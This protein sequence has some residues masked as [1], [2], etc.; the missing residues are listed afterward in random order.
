LDGHFRNDIVLCDGL[1]LYKMSAQEMVGE[2]VQGE[3]SKAHRLLLL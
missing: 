1:G 3:P 2:E